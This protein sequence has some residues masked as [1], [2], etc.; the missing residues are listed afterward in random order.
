[1]NVMKCRFSLHFVMAANA[2]GMD[3]A[4]QAA[5]AIAAHSR[6]RCGV[7]IARPAVQEGHLGSASS[8][9]P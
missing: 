7:V 9:I 5:R 3:C 8:N 4:G 6:L 1:M 2:R